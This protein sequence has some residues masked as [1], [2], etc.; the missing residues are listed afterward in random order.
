MRIICEC[1]M[2]VVYFV[3]D[4]LFILCLKLGL[5]ENLLCIGWIVNRLFSLNNLFG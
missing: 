5:I 4:K 2:L 3:N 1:V